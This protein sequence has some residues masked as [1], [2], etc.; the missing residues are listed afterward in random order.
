MLAPMMAGAVKCVE[1]VTESRTGR[2]LKRIGGAEYATTAAADTV[3]H[4]ADCHVPATYMAMRNGSVVNA[5][6]HNRGACMFLGNTAPSTPPLRGLLIPRGA[7]DENEQKRRAHKC[8]HGAGLQRHR[9]PDY[10][11]GKI[12]EQQASAAEQRARGKNQT[13]IRPPHEPHHVW[14]DKPDKRDDAC[15]C[16]PGSGRKRRREEHDLPC[17]FHSYPRCVRDSLPHDEE[18]ELSGVDHDANHSHHE[19][20]GHESDIG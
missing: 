5:D 19:G 2:S 3:N 18:V 20:D 17:S 13:M 11:R 8:C 1:E 10:P 16:Y 6:A 14:N 9:L 12:R 4:R 7:D 15:D